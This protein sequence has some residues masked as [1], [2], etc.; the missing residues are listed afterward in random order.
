[1]L[2]D[3]GLAEASGYL[4]EKTLLGTR[5]FLGMQIAPLVYLPIPG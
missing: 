2:D 5:P 1:M 3:A 4:E